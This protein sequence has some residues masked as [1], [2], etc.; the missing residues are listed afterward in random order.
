M[1]VIMEEMI[2]QGWQKWP[3]CGSI[4]SGLILFAQV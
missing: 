4:L 1:V 3:W 2:G